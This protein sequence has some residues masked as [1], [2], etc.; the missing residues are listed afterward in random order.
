MMGT[1]AFIYAP[2]Y[3]KYGLAGTGIIGP[4]TVVIFGIARIILEVRYKVQQGVWLK[5]K[6]SRV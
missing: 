3:A 2:E 4:G 1:G 6:G 5:K